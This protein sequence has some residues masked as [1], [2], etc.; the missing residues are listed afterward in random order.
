MEVEDSFN[1]DY[2]TDVDVDVDNAN[3]LSPD[4]VAIQVDDITL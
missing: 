2:S 1:D 3:I 4:A